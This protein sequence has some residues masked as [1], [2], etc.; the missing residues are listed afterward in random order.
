MRAFRYTL[1]LT[2]PIKLGEQTICQRRGILL[3]ENERWSEASP[4]P[5]FSRET[6][7]DVIAALRGNR[8]PPPSLEFAL[9]SLQQPPSEGA[10]PLNALLQGQRDQVLE[11]TS[12]LSESSCQTVKLKVGRDRVENEIQLVQQ[13]RR[14]L[15][16]D[17]R[18]RLDANRAWDWPS[19]ITFANG[20]SGLD[21]EY[22]EEPLR[23]VSRL[24]EFTTETGLAYAMDESLRETCSLA[25]FPSAKALIVKPT[26][27]GGRQRVSE[28]ASHGKPLTFSACYESGIGLSH[29]CQLA[30]QFAPNV[31]A[32]LDTYR[33]LAE[34][35]LRERLTV[36]NWRIHIT[37]PLTPDVS[38]LEKV[39][40]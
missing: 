22:I 8:P 32:G 35:V 12:V 30:L 36:Q 19:A 5:H 20:V 14:L 6:E 34:D 1:P 33:Y 9:D 40:L 13:V 17:Q 29:I 27:V 28:L 23:D 31:P 25:H 10:I 26:I 18:L 38:R 24:E 7:S 11:Q 15:R 16:R 4:L 2:M 39:D 37:D 3:E 21:I